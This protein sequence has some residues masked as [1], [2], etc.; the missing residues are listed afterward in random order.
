MAILSVG[1]SQAISA[2]ELQGYYSGSEGSIVLRADGSA[3]LPS[4][5]KDPSAD[6]VRWRQSGDDSVWLT[7]FY[8]SGPREFNN[9]YDLTPVMFNV[10]RR[11]GKIVLS[12]RTLMGSYSFSK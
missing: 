6:G 7:P 1:W 5:L 12:T 4:A 10:E 2:E 8:Y 9:T 3:S 11:D